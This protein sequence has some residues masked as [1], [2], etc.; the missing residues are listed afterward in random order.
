MLCTE[1]RWLAALSVVLSV[2]FAGCASDPA[3]LARDGL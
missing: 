3:N 2:G 1:Q